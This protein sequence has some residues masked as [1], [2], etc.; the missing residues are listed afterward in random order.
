MFLKDSI[1][2]FD[3]GAIESVIGRLLVENKKTISFAESCSGGM[4]SAAV[5]NVSGSSSYFK[6]SVVVYS[7]YLKIKLLSVKEETLADYGSVSSETAK[8]MAEG[9][10]RL[11]GSDYAFSTTGIAGPCGST[12]EKPIGLVYVGFADKNKAESFKFNFSGTRL[13]VRKKTVDAVL[14]LLRRRLIA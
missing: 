4:I 12:K 7:N 8:E 13:E 9:I 2:D 3:K 6:G 14:D 10:L 1:F 11:S 5:T